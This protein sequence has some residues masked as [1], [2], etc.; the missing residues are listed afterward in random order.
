MP[1]RSRR[2]CTIVFISNSFISDNFD[3]TTLIVTKLQPERHNYKFCCIIVEIYGYQMEFDKSHLYVTIPVREDS[4][5]INASVESLV[6]QRG[7]NPHNYS[8]F[9]LVSNTKTEA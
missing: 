9:Y 3:N 2:P 1:I 8:I 4:A 6:N 5:E 7:V